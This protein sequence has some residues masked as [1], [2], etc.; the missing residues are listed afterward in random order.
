MRG[1]NL[2]GNVSAQFRIASPIHLPHS[3]LAELLED[4]ERYD[5]AT[6]VYDTVPRDD[7]S[8]HA[9]ELGR[10]E[11]LRRS[12]EPL[13]FDPDL[14]LMDEPLGALDKNLRLDMQIE[15]KRLQR[16]LG[17]TAILVTHDRDEAFA[18]ATDLV[19]EED[20]P[21]VVGLMYVM[22]LLGMIVSALVFGALLSLWIFDQTLNIF[23][24][25]G[26]IMLIGLV[27]KNAI[28]IVEFANQLRSRG[29]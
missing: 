1:K 12:G 20:Q 14:V 21:K 3:T 26:L 9:A 15:L 28:L 10:A 2:D 19:P 7:P 6:E 11:A 23:S 18:L 5:L 17:L 16:Q 4:L 24:R 22:L 27:T 8:F 29:R 25:I 13:V